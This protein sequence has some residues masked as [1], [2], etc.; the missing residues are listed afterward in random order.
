MTS[1][2]SFPDNSV[3]AGVPAKLINTNGAEGYIYNYIDADGV[4]HPRV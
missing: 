1:S 4:L 3:V 2:K